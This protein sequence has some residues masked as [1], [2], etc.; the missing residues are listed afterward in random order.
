[1]VV[2]IVLVFLI[3]GRGGLGD[4]VGLPRR[5]V[6]VAGGAAAGGVLLGEEIVPELA[7]PILAVVPLCLGEIPDAAAYLRI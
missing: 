4:I 6:V 3:W 7:V 2:L 1:V 5:E